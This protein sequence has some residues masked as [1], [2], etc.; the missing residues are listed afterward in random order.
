M[1]IIRHINIPQTSFFLFGPRGTGKST[2]VKS[3][4]KKDTL[5]IDFLEPDTFRTFSAF[6]ETLI[7]T[8]N[9]T[10]PVQVIID[11][12]QK[13]PQILDVVHKIME[14]KKIRFI[15]TG[16]SARKL[17]KSGADLLGGRALNFRMHPF[18][19]AELGNSFSLDK[20]LQTGLIPVVE[21]SADPAK[22]LS[23]Y[24]DIY[25]REEIQAEGM[26]RNLGTFARFLEI[27]SFSHGTV[28]NISNLARECQINRGIV[29]GYMDILE[30]LLLAYRLPVFA[31]RAKRKTASHPKFYFFDNGLYRRLR[32]RGPLDIESE[33]SGPAVEGLVGQHLRAYI[34]F[35]IP[36]TQLYY[37]RTL[38]GNEVDFILYGIKTFTAIEVK[39]SGILKPVDYNGLI[40]FGDDYPEASLILIYRGTLMMKHK[41]ILIV[42]LEIFLKDP[43]EYFGLKDK[44]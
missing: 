41:N 26:V 29:S 5:Y 12:V 28:L 17:K 8:V 9:A 27:I 15:L 7:K 40:S 36:D 20:A 13:I 4:I 44:K 3:L 32:Q 11:E 33:I 24:V 21:R 43:G 42:P 34:D 14:E 39:N 10:D 37:W 25:L 18:T 35:A 22:S 1:K 31:K 38:A 6:P 30:D 16:S 23:A 19:A 2:F